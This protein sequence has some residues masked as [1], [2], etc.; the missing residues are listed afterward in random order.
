MKHL[1]D[2]NAKPNIPPPA[3]K[4]GMASTIEKGNL[5]NNRMKKTASCA[6]ILAIALIVG[7]FGNSLGVVYAQQ[8]ITKTK[9]LPAD[10]KA[11]LAVADDAVKVNTDPKWMADRLA[12]MNT[13]MSYSHLLD[14]RHFEEWGKLFTDDIVL[15]V[16][17]PGAGAVRAKG[18]AL[19]YELV[20]K[21]YAA[22][23]AAKRRHFQGNVHVT[24]QTATTARILVYMMITTVP[25]RDR[26]DVLTSGTYD[27][28]LRKMPDGTWRIN[29]WSIV[30]D[31]PVSPIDITGLEEQV[32]FLP[33]PSNL[34]HPGA[35]LGPIKGGITLANHPMGMPFNGPMYENNETGGWKWEDSD[36][37]IVDYIT[38]AKAAAAFLPEQMTTFPIAEMPGKALVKL[39]FA[40]YRKVTSLGPYKELIVQIPALYKGNLSMY[41]PAIY[42]DSDRAMSSG[43]EIGGYPKK[44]AKI[45]IEQF[46]NEWRA[47][48][49]RDGK[50]IISISSRQGA[51]LTA[52]PLPADKQVILPFPY[53]LTFPLP[54]PTGKP[55]EVLPLPL[56]SLQVIPGIGSDKPEPALARLLFAN[57]QMYGTFYKGEA[58]S[59]KI[60]P[61]END[62]IYKLPV[63]QV[64][65]SMHGY[66]GLNAF[67]KDVSVLE[68][69]TPKK[70]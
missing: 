61:S 63:M 30:C 28:T 8:D 24:E 57:W 48:L 69:L 1:D 22:P 11:D 21:R 53:N 64:L 62:P 13:V 15:E 70:K 55:Q 42:V 20:A 19:F 46:G 36:F 31:A 12:I 33:D 47:S 60:S 32:E 38:D 54:A 3:N 67:F 25:N 49:E 52:T 18:H 34:P 27:G 14:E 65:D 43:R 35:V 26:Q 59:L 51:K 40:D 17:V 6:A 4:K 16:I 50:R 39:L 45:D 56:T 9:P 44:L 7:L 41:I 58:A 5:M 2:Q 37:I 10:Y 66:G 68:D 23:T 29:R